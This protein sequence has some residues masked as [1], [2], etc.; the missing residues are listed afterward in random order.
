MA[1]KRCILGGIIFIQILIVIIGGG[2]LGWKEMN[3][4][5]ETPSEILVKNN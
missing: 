1:K 5:N 4:M 3:K 2:I